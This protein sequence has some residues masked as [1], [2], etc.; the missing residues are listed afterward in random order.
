MLVITIKLKSIEPEEKVDS[1][2]RG[3]I[4]IQGKYGVISS[5]KLNKDQSMMIFISIVEL[6]DG[7]R[8]FFLNQ[9]NQK[10]NFV[11]TDS[12]FQFFLIKSESDKFRLTDINNKLIDET[13]QL[14]IIN[15]VWKEVETFISNYDYFL[16]EKE[17]VKNDLT[18]SIN[19]FKKQFNL[20][21]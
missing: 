11:G 8:L 13:T 17:I 2:S 7:I 19:A 1:Y 9:D 14:D 20:N 10:Y 15:A 5:E 12:S 3:H 18:G 21:N 6:L 4:E 16:D